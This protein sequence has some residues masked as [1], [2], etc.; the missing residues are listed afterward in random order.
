LWQHPTQPSQVPSTI[1]FADHA[2]AP[3]PS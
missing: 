3:T 2:P 1:P